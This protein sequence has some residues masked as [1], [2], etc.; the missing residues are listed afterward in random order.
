[1]KK[2]YRQGRMG[3]EIR[4][5]VSE[6]LVKGLKDPKL[7]GAVSVS[8]VDV[9]GDGSHATLYI[10]AQ[11]KAAGET[12][13]ECEKKELLNALGRAK[14]LLR[15]EI[16]SQLHL[17]HAPELVFKLDVSQEYG[18]RI[19]SIFSGL[20]Y[21]AENEGDACTDAGERDTGE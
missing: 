10:L 20:T 2:S 8:G 3:E 16:G 6:L 17:R 1:M 5:I 13:G 12:V 14:G 21:S 18:R 11:W 7:S 4:R 15:R 9:T 19:E